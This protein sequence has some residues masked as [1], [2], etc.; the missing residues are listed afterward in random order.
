[1]YD[2]KKI[3][4]RWQQY[5]EKTKLY[6]VDIKNAKRPFY[7]LMMF[8]YPSAEGLHV[9]NVFAFTGSDVYGR[10]KRLSGYDVFEP[11]GFD[12]FG[13]HSEN[14]AIKS[15]IHPAQLIPKNIEN[16]RENQLK[17]IGAMFDW[18]HQ[19]DTTDPNYYKWTQWLFLQ[20]YHA[21]LAYRKKAP[22]N[23]CPSC[24]TVLA[25]EQVESGL[26]ERCKSVVEPKEMEQWFFKITNYTERLLDNLDRIDWSEITKTAQRRWIGK[27]EGM[28]V[29][30]EIINQNTN[31][32]IIHGCCDDSNDSAYDKHWLPWV[33]EELIKRGIKCTT[34][35]MPEPWQADYEAWKQE[36]AQHEMNEN[37]ILI[38]HSCGCAFLVRYLG[39]TKKT[40]NKL[41]LVAPWKISE[42]GSADK[43][44]YD[45]E[46][47]TTIKER[48][49]EII[50]FTA[51]DEEIDGKFSAQ[52]FYDSLGGK[53]ITLSGKGHYTLLDMGSE[54]FPELLDKIINHLK[55]YTTRVDTIFGATYLAISPEHP[56][57]KKLITKEYAQEAFA[58]IKKA[59]FKKTIEQ[60][61]NDKNKTG[62]FTGTY[63]INPATK[64]TIPIWI[65][66]YVLTTYGTG[67]IM[68]V[69][70]HDERDYTF[71]KK[72]DIPIM[73]VI[74]P[75]YEE[76]DENTP[77]NDVV[78]N[79]IKL[80]S[81]VLKPYPEYKPYIGEGIMI[82]SGQ[83]NDL[84][85]KDALI[86]ITKWLEKENKGIQKTNY[87]LRDWCISRQRYWGP[88]IP[89]I[90]CNKCGIVPVPEAELPVLLPMVEDFRPKG[91]GTSPLANI[92]DFINTTCPC[93]GG[94]GQRESDVMDNFLDSAWYFFRYP[95][96]DFDDK[97]FDTDIIKK[98]LPVAM[99]IGGNEH[100]VLH[101]MY[102]RFITMVLKDLGFID[103]EEPF[104]KF[105]AHG[106]ILKDGYKMSK[107]KGNV[108]NPDEYINH[109]GADVFRL[110]LLFL[111]PYQEGGDFSDD[112]IKGI[113][114]FLTRVYQYYAQLDIK[115]LDLTKMASISDSKLLQL[116][117]ATIKEVTTDIELLK[118]NTAIA[119]LRSMFNYLERYKINNRDTLTVFIK[120]L[121]VFTPHL[122]EEIWSLLGNKDSIFNSAWPTY[123]ET[124][125]ITTTYEL[126]VQVNGKVRG[127]VKVPRD[128][129]KNQMEEAALNIDNVKRY[130]KDNKITNIIIVPNRLVNIVFKSNIKGD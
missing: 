16:F 121:S 76:T 66:D 112:G 125:T 53:L 79:K 17:K 120:M 2:F 21:G 103:F 110:Y 41:I 31:C 20:L 51:D 100:A 32:I 10:Y 14:F 34:P 108:V 126:I 63:A 25:N 55:V 23:W 48:V 95:C 105:R 26:C 39:E 93:C 45:Y 4:N 71:A 64:K 96:T 29:N 78:K 47:D 40:I 81:I 13:I 102:T 62:V 27:S 104:K 86:K 56:L 89:I 117:H 46:I 60:E 106:L 109:Y 5:W 50:I 59:K 44:F 38:G 115:N 61:D 1:M 129:S 22:V 28:E 99:Y 84:E 85:S 54:E 9:G 69:P 18:R 87:Q 124:K 80:A 15:G 97:P 94:K 36:M 24:L 91:S 74:A 35:L 107:S 3:E 73:Q 90:Y 88:P 67:A 72:Y 77:R 127:K 101:L 116:V 6:E 122:A 19:V 118:Y 57:T 43:A 123:D 98:W 7:N 37:T 49:K 82:N 52:L 30:F 65:S 70:A 114:R 11:M 33:R 42:T 113:S 8:P 119:K 58:Y 75:S 128:L 111:G 92:H 12:A 130:I 83:F 68:G